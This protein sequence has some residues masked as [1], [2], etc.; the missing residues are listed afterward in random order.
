MTYVVCAR[1]RGRNLIVTVQTGPIY[2]GPGKPNSFKVPLS[3][4]VAYVTVNN[5]A[6]SVFGAVNVASSGK[7]TLVVGR[8]EQKVSTFLLLMA[9]LAKTLDKKLDS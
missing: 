9:E 2:S 8:P 6:Q 5:I 1:D 7:S 3:P 4:D